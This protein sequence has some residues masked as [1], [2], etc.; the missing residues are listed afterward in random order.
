VNLS[1]PC[2]EFL[3]RLDTDRS[4]SV[5]EFR[6]FM[7][8]LFRDAPPP[9]YFHVRPDDREDF[10]SAVFLHCIDNDCANLRRYR[11]RQG[12]L[13]VGWLATVASRK[14][15]DMLKKER[16]RE[17][18]HTTDDKHDAVNPAQNPEQETL[19]KEM[20]KIFWAALRQLD[21][22]C[23]LLLRLRYL[24]YSN[25]EIVRILRLPKEHNKSI[26]NAVL[27]CRKKL[28]RRLRSGGFF[29]LGER[30]V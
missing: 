6:D 4:A 27:E 18:H 22:T 26:G 24:E 11:H 13:F 8:Q 5:A 2:P 19:G 9:S 16:T 25:R 1:D 14:I 3:A 15:S 17:Q 20:R 28:A 21:H 10:V 29:D 30:G 12:S 23:R 7:D